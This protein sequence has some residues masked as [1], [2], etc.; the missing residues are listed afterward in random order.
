[1]INAG[2]MEDWQ[3]S[4]TYEKGKVTKR[5]R[6]GEAG[7][8]CPFTISSKAFDAA[9]LPEMPGIRISR[10]FFTSRENRQLRCRYP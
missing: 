5:S 6:G 9:L 1:V 2:D 3:L 7:Y 8:W 4:M 10:Q